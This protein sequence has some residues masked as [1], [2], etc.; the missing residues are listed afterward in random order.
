MVF[1]AYALFPHMTVAENVGYG[2]KLRRTPRPELAAAVEAGLAQVGL[3]GYGDRRIWELSGGQQQRVQLARALVLRPA[4]L[5][6]DEPLAALDAKLRKEM[7]F[8]LKQLQETVGI[9]FV[10]VT[11]NQEEAMTVGDRIALVADGRLV[12]EGSPEE[13]YTRPRRRFT[14][15]FVGE[16][17]VLD[18]RVR[19]VDGGV[20]RVE[21]P[22]GPVDA[23]T[24]GAEPRVGDAA[25]IS[26]RG[27]ALRV[28]DPGAAA[29]GAAFPASFRDDVYLG[30]VTQTHARLSDGTMVVA[31]AVGGAE[32]APR[33]RHGDP[34][35]IA[36]R[37]EDV[38]LHLD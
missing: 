17:M 19:A 8:E 11:H 32:G 22:C 12:E 31:R 2:L 35:A 29:E 18:G 36:W 34:V 7:C 26:V 4:I 24:R 1:Q 3:T 27:E 5:L 28:L 23:P 21:T 9:T 33:R 25:A 20:A 6:L 14:A 10:H 38:L 16:R 30:L 37:T 13:V 15:D